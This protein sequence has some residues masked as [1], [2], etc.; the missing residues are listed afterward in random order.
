MI[1]LNTVPVIQVNHQSVGMR[2][3]VIA[4]LPRGK[5]ISRKYDVIENENKTAG[6]VTEKIL[7]IACSLDRLQYSVFEYCK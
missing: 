1:T 2:D 7:S 4:L 6:S 3:N 5:S